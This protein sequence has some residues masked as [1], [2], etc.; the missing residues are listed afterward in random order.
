MSEPLILMKIPGRVRE[1]L[2]SPELADHGR[3]EWERCLV[4]LESAEHHVIGLGVTCHLTVSL[5]DA[6]I[7]VAEISRAEA[8]ERTYPTADR[9]I[10]PYVPQRLLKRLNEQIEQAEA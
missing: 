1:W 9:L 3:T 6:R 10:D 4:L 2:R 8:A 7:L 5:Q